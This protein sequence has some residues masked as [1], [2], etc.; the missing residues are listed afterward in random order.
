M[1]DRLKNYRLGEFTFPPRLVYDRRSLKR[2]IP[3]HKPLALRF[4]LGKDFALYRGRA[5]GK[6]C[7]A[8][9]VLPPHE[10][11]TLRAQQNIL[12]GQ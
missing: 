12:R 11:P 9:C 6:R 10:G 4:F 1:A 7:S 3:P 2:S 5:S 8:G